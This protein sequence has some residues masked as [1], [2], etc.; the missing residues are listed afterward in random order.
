MNKVI[1]LVRCCDTLV[2]FKLTVLRAFSN[3]VKFPSASPPDPELED[4]GFLP[5]RAWP[6]QWNNRIRPIG[7]G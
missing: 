2:L 4:G 6:E 5:L 3:F 7:I 1:N